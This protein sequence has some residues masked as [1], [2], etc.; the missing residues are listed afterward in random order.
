MAI[1]GEE[2]TQEFA[3]AALGV[4]D[5]KPNCRYFL[6][7]SESG[8]IIDREDKETGERE[9]FILA[10][11]SKD[12]LDQFD[13]EPVPADDDAEPIAD[14]ALGAN[15]V[16]TVKFTAFKMFSHPWVVTGVLAVVSGLF[17]WFVKRLAGEA[18]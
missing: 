3:C 11:D 17:V 15:I 7:T 10:P 1:G 13:D 18:T 6:H 5:Y 12:V 4:E 8:F 14:L 9:V 2:L 16:E